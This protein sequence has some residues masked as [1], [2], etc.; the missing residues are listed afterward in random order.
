[1]ITD[2]SYDVVLEGVVDAFD[3]FEEEEEEE[4]NG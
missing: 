1:M 2:T 3:D 4:L